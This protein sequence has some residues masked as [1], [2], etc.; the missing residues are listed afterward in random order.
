MGITGR[1]PKV[2]MHYNLNEAADTLATAKE[3]INRQVDV[4]QNRAKETRPNRLTGMHW[5]RRYSSISMPKTQVAS[6]RPH[7]LKSDLFEETHQFLA[8][9][10]GKAAHTDICWI[11]TS[12]SDGLTRSFSKQSATTSR[13]R[14]MS[15]SRFLA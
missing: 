5:Y 15:V 13:T 3:V 7:N 12:S 8:P 6:P 10:A 2:L 14:F 11:P 1:V 4:T 9:Q